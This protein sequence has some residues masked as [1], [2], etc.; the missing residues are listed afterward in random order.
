[1][2]CSLTLLIALSEL[3]NVPLAAFWPIFLTDRASQC[4]ERRPDFLLAELENF[5]WP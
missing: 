5:G 1:M 2:A 3:E 4:P